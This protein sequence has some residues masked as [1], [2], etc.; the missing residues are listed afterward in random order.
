ML[1]FCYFVLTARN[2]KIA[3]SSKL[4]ILIANKKKTEK[5]QQ[6]A[7]KQTNNSRNEM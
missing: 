3:Y 1:K 6:Q 5:N 7:S 4:F 2:N